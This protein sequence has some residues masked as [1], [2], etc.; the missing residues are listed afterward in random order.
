MGRFRSSQDACP[1]CLRDSS[2]PKAQAATV[3]LRIHPPLLPHAAAPGGHPFPAPL[4]CGCFCNECFKTLS[5]G[6]P[7]VSTSNSTTLPNGTVITA[8]TPGGEGGVPGHSLLGLRQAH[9]PTLRDPADRCCML[10]NASG[11]SCRP[12]SSF[13]LLASSSVRPA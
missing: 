8:T 4:Q 5:D 12:R 6:T 10:R 11:G 2:A 9:T 7:V 1:G 13:P 3:C